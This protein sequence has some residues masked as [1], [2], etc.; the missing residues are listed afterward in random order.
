MIVVIDYDIG[1]V[2]SVLN[3]IEFLGYETLLSRAPRLMANANGLI[4]PGVGAFG[5]GMKKLKRLGLIDPI[6]EMIIKGEKPLL[7]ICLG[8]QL[9]GQIGYEHGVHK[10]LSLIAGKVERLNTGNKNLRLPHI[11]WNDVEY[12]EGS[13]LF[14]GLVENP[15]FYFIHDF[16][17]IPEED[18]SIIGK[19]A[20][21]LTFVSAVQHQNIYGTQFH[22]EKSQRNGLMVIDNFIKKICG[23]NGNPKNVH[24]VGIMK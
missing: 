20:Y 19:T 9:L 1:N 22:P 10:G 16:A 23:E 2:R 4:L 18:T 7:G 3:A 12:K 14:S 24:D 8:M 5:D 11:G 6:K 17:F 15:S 13:I 21:G